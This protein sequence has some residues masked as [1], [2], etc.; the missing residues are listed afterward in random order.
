MT[1]RKSILAL[2]RRKFLGGA[3]A[4]SGIAASGF[5]TRVFAQEPAKPAEIIVRAWGG[6]WVD[7]LKAGVSDPFTAATGIAVR[8][9]LTED[10]EI[11]PK[12][13]AAV[14]QNRVPPIHINWDTTTNAT[15]S[16]LRGVT[17]D[18]SDLSNLAGTT[19]LAK[20][21]GLEGYPIVNTYG[22]VYVLAYRPEAFPD[23]APTSL[24]VLLDPKFKG[25]IALYNDGI[26]FHFPA[27]VAGGGKLEDIP[28]NMQPAW[29]FIAKVKQQ[30][31]LLG[32]DPDFTTWFQNGEIDL[33]VTISTNAREA[34]KNGVN[35]AWTVPEE[36][37]KFD[38]DG[39]W[40]PK[41]LPENELYWAK[42]YINFAITKD[43]QQVWLD[44]LGLPGVVPGLTPPADLVGDP[45][46]PTKPEDFE[47][48]IRISS[49]VQVENESTWFG[50][51]KKIMQG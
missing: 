17:E 9:D 46:Y 30:A 36:G 21:V 12:V 5:A 3:A 22:Y 41:G 33:A 24:Q 6:S 39:L 43:A 13:W 35:I 7:S 25:R 37:A 18:L 16:A 31:P 40:I 27:Q 15:K 11:Q 50:E 4:L 23:G 44:G 51:F 49:Q 2:S 1:D 38:T 34:K 8:H 19:D 26:G 10:N 32:E 47:H 28:A 45:S 48:L 20:P 29:D 42:Q 14:A